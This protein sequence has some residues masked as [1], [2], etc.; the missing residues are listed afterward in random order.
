[1]KIWRVELTEGRSLTE[2]MIQRDVFQGDAL[3]PLLLMIAIMPLTK[4][5]ENAQPHTN[6]VDRKKNK[7]PIVHG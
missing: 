3:T 1:M 5:S 2:A 6:S 4:Y 7:L